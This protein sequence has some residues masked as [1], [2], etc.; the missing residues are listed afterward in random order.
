MNQNSQI[1]SFS[2]HQKNSKKSISIK[3]DSVLDFD[4]KIRLNGS[5]WLFLTWNWKYSA[6]HTMPLCFAKH[7]SRTLRILHIL[8]GIRCPTVFPASSTIDSPHQKNS[9]KSISIKFDSVL[10]FDMKIRLNGSYWLFLTWNWKYS[11]KHTMPLCFA[12]HH[13]RTLGILHILPGISCP[14]VFPASSTIE[15]YNS[16][17]GIALMILKNKSW[18]LKFKLYFF[19]SSDCMFVGSTNYTKIYHLNCRQP[20]LWSSI[21]SIFKNAVFFNNNYY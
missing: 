10:D 2:P 11:A 13:S 6:K 18:I 20:L 19:S 21:R 4:M 5:Y 1:K 8:P 17:R 7:H 3:F 9:K 16:K 14:T 15:N 12:K